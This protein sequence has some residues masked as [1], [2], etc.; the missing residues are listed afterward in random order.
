MLKKYKELYNCYFLLFFVIFILQ[1]IKISNF[2]YIRMDNN[3]NNNVNIFFSSTPSDFNFRSIVFYFVI[4]CVIVLL[5]V[6][7]IESLCTFNNISRFLIRPL[8]K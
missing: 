2:L 5:V 6:F 8:V 4:F 3:N 1:K 7:G